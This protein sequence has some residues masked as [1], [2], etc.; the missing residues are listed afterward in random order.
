MV[1][2]PNRPPIEP[3][4]TRPTSCVVPEADRIRSWPADHGHL[5][6]GIVTV[7]HR[8]RAQPVGGWVIRRQAICWC[9]RECMRRFSRWINAGEVTRR[10]IGEGHRTPI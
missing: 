4:T 7:A 10:V 2:E 5:A 3:D 8:T 9:V 1:G 6:G